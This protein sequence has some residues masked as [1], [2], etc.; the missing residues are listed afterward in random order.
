M[1]VESLK[2]KDGSAAVPEGARLT[3][4]STGPVIALLDICYTPLFVT[5]LWAR[6]GALLSVGL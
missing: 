2:A 5:Y 1:P 3:S 4:D 6:L